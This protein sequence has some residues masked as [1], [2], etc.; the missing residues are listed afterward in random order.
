MARHLRLMGIYFWL[1]ALFTLG[2]SALWLGGAEYAKT[3]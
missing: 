3:R 1:L 2:R